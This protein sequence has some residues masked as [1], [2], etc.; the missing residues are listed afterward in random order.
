MSNSAIIRFK[1]NYFCEV[2]LHWNGGIESIVGFL[3]YCELKGYRDGDF[4]RFIQVVGNFF[5]GGNT[6]YLEKFNSNIDTDNGIYL[7][8]NWK[9]VNKKVDKNIFTKQ[10]F[11][12]LFRIIN[13]T[14][15]KEEQLPEKLFDCK[16]VSVD[17]LKIGDTV[18]M[19]DSLY[20]NYNERVI[21]GK[22]EDKFYVNGFK[23]DNGSYE[24]NINNYINTKTI[25]RLKSLESDENNG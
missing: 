20:Y 4:A 5:G 23:D 12:E 24:T 13:S 22:H 16:E 25:K 11:K 14:Q 21:V 7:V 9:I 17:D 1:D 8:H 10:S 3:K 15:R 19:Y 2:Y 6:I 18:F